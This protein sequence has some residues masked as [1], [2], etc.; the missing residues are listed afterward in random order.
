MKKSLIAAFRYSYLGCGSYVMN[1]KRLHEMPTLISRKV[2]AIGLKEADA[3]CRTTL[4][5]CDAT[6]PL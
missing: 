5:D 3:K 1:I 6:I 4:L 2:Y